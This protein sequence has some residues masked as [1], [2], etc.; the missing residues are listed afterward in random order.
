M[1]S[2]HCSQHGTEVLL[3]ERRIISIEV[4]ADTVLVRF[5]CRCG[6]EGEFRDPR[7]TAASAA[8][9]TGPSHHVLGR[10]QLA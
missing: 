7:L 3:T 2:A 5:R 8:D 4:E 10:R 6:T 1:F 9:L